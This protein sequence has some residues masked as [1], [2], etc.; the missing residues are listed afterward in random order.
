[1]VVAFSAIQSVEKM[2]LSIG[3]VCSAIPSVE[4]MFLSNGFVCVVKYSL[5]RECFYLMVVV[6]SAMP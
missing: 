4:G 2:F 5:W 3:C 6:F 1:M